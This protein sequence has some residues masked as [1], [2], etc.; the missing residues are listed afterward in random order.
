M[1]CLAHP[2]AANQTFLVADGED[3]STPELLRRV[4]EA[5]GKAPRLLPVPIWLLE[6][7]AMLLG[8]RAAVHRLCGSLHIDI[9]K[10]QAL[11]NWTP[12]QSVD[13]AIRLTA[14]HFLG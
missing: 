8:K 10:A 12:P 11:L 14:R 5:L 9:S 2:A 1:T 6:A 13:Q 3:M 7:G 4:S